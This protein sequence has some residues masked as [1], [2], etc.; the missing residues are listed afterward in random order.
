MTMSV[1]LITYDVVKSS[2]EVDAIVAIIN[3]YKHIQLSEGSYAIE[4]HEKTR[5]VFNKF[6]PCL[7]EEAHLLVA[8]IIKPFAGAVSAPVSDW[9]TK[10]LSEY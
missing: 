3:S 5:T 10:H 4:T 6:L 9:L 8:T 7:G 2:P 1:L